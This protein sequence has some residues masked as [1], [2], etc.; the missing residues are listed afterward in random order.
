MAIRLIFPRKSRRR[1]STAARST[2]RIGRRNCA[3]NIAKNIA[4]N[5]SGNRYGEE[6]QIE[7]QAG[8]P[9]RWKSTWRETELRQEAKR[10]QCEPRR[11]Q[12]GCDGT[13]QAGSIES[14]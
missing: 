1:L 5:R 9:S 10:N 3:T 11:R 4:A 7:S 2:C 14:Q 6:N 8:R 13:Q 12:R